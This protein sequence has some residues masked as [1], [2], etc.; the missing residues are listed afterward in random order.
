MRRS[1]CLD[2]GSRVGWAGNL[3]CAKQSSPFRP[4]LNNESNQAMANSQ[5]DFSL[6][7]MVPTT[8]PTH[9]PPTLVEV[10]QVVCCHVDALGQATHLLMQTHTRWVLHHG[11]C[12]LGCV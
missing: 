10:V 11:V 3:L 2:A 8:T 9:N 7:K 6:I 12:Y 1:V 5:A 4:L